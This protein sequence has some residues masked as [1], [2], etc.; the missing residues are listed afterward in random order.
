MT[1]ARVVT[2]IRAEQA[3]GV[4]SSGDP[5]R[6]PCSLQK[7]YVHP[8][9]CSWEGKSTMQNTTAPRQRPL[10]VTIMSVL[11]GIQGLIE[12]IGGITLIV[13]ANSL[14]HRIIA[15]GHAI[16]ARFVDTFGVALGVVGIIVGIITLFFVYGLWTLKRWAYWTV[17]II[18]GLSLLRSIFE[19]IRHTGTTAGVIAGMIIP[20]IVFLYFLLDPNVRRAFRV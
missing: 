2:T 7:S 12:L 10:G 17:I 16:I 3:P 8:L 11:L 5:L 15:H 20:A 6:S 13:V 1:T 18:E 9:I 19:L 14:T 4:Y